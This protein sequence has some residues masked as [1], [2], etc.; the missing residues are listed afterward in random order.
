MSSAEFLPRD[1]QRSSPFPV[2]F[3]DE[4]A[5]GFPR[6]RASFQ[7]SSSIFLITSLTFKV[8]PFQI[9]AKINSH[10]SRHICGVGLG[11]AVAEGILSGVGLGVST[12]LGDGEA[13]GDGELSGV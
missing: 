8:E 2:S 7:P 13:V 1:G 9:V 3:D 6:V 10:V 12:G 11:V 5:G 4:I